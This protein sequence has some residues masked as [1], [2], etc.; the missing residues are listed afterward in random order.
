MGVGVGRP[1]AAP[2]PRCRPAARR[3]K[4]KLNKLSAAK[5]KQVFLVSGSL[6]SCLALTDSRSLL[7]R[8]RMLRNLNSKC[9]V[10]VRVCACEAHLGRAAVLLRRRR[11]RERLVVGGRRLHVVV[12]VVA[13][14]A[15]EGAEDAAA[16]VLLEAAV[17][18]GDWRG[19]AQSRWETR[20]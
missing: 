16:A 10:R 8:L 11:Q 7:L 3:E 15:E 6:E 9:D 4:A 1:A 13:E 18:L 5:T 2:P 14:A 12:I 17:G 20:V 19:E